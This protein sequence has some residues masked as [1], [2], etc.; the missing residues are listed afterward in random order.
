MIDELNK[1]MPVIIKTIERVHDNSWVMNYNQHDGYELIYVKK[2][3]LMF[4][5]EERKV[6]LKNGELLIIKPF[7]KHKFEVISDVKAEFIVLGF[8]LRN[9]TKK[10]LRDVYGFIEEVENNVNDY[11]YIKVKKKSNIFLCLEILLEEA[12]KNTKSL[13]QHLKCLELFI[14]ITREMSK[15]SYKYM[16]DNSLIAKKIKEIIEKNYQYD[17]KIGDIAKELYITESNLCRIFKKEFG[18]LPKEYLLKLRIEKA[19]EY[20]LQDAL[21]VGEVALICGFSSI[22]RFNEVFKKYTNLSPKEFK[23][24][25]KNKQGT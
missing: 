14:Y 19:K 25:F 13:L 10:K 20:L 9:E 23:M 5:I 18:M 21:K 16:S 11:Y 7:K 22:Q 4:W 8:Q 12:K 24:Q 2:G 6:T 1:I 15:N 17:I 3:M